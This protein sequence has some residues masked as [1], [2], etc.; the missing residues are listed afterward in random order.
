MNEAAV[1]RVE[2]VAVFSQER[3]DVSVKKAT[4]MIE[5]IM[6]IGMGLLV[7][8]VALALLLPIFKMGGVVAG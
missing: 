5:P 1:F 7:G 8:A 2:K 3:L 4:T 6:I